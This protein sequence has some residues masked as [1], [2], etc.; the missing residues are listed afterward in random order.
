[1]HCATVG[2]LLFSHR[3]RHSGDGRG[4]QIGFP[5]ANIDTHGQVCP[6]NGVY[7]IRAQLE[8]Q[9]LDGVLNIG[10]RPTFDG[11]TVQIECHFFDFHETIYGKSVEIFLIKKIRSEQKF[12]TLKHSFNKYNAISR[13]Q[14]R[15]SQ[16]LTAQPERLS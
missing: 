3:E 2:T 10:V 14:R 13:Q 7:A 4:R 1:M 11:T 6:P 9:Q 16:R 12:R 8:G 15:F 5:T